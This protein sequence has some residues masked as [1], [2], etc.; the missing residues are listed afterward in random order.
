LTAKIGNSFQAPEA[1]YTT[2]MK[3]VLFHQGA[4]EFNQV[5]DKLI[6][7]KLEAQEKKQNEEELFWQDLQ[8]K[9]QTLVAISI[10][11]EQLLIDFSQT[12]VP[13]FSQNL[14][15]MIDKYTRNYGHFLTEFVKANEKYFQDLE[16]S[17]LKDMTHKRGYE[18][19]VRTASKN[20]GHESMKII[21]DLQKVKKPTPELMRE[22]TKKVKK[23]FEALKE[24]LN[25]RLIQLT[26]DRAQEKT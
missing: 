5:L 9:L 26:E 12:P 3:I 2:R 16:K 23:K 15:R 19:L 4:V 11:I 1:S 10:Q 7:K 8:Q 14:K 18:A 22:T 21:E 20:I 25:K 24:G 6:Q 13:Q 17:G